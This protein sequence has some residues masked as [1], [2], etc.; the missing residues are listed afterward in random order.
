MAMENMKTHNEIVERIKQ[1]ED[2]YSEFEDKYGGD[3]EFADSNYCN[4]LYD[5][6]NTLRWVI[7]ESPRCIVAS[8]ENSENPMVVKADKLDYVRRRF[9]F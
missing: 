5:A 4:C 3:K 8:Y 6:I 2:F 7:G 9:K 1:M